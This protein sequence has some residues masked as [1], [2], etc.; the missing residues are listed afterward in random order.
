L[1]LV[2]LNN[3]LFAVLDAIRA[4]FALS[5]NKKM[6]RIAFTLLVIVKHKEVFCITVS[7]FSEVITIHASNNF[8]IARVASI[9]I[10]DSVRLALAFSINWPLVETFLRLALEA[11][12]GLLALVAAGYLALNAGVVEFGVVQLAG[13]GV[14]GVWLLVPEFFS[15]ALLTFVA[16]FR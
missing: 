8:L 6:I 16:G 11:C 4:F 9:S 7:T 5:A 13:A 2:L 15:V 3:A 12:V 14:V 1:L 10:V